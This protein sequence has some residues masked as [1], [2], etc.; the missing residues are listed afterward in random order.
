MKTLNSS[1]L[2]EALTVR[3]K[4]ISK[5]DYLIEKGLLTLDQAKPW[6]KII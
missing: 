2:Q 3:G 1:I 5:I 6:K 4:K